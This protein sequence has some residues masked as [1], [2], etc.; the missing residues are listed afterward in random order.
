MDPAGNF[1]SKSDMVAI[2][3]TTFFLTLLS[4]VSTLFVETTY[5]IYILLVIWNSSRYQKEKNQKDKKETQ[6]EGEKSKAQTKQKK[7]EE[8]EEKS[9]K[10]ETKVS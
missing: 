6:V 9:Q 4:L 1:T 8:D 3:L 2:N 10:Q 5:S 7:E